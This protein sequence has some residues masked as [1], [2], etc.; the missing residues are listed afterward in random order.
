MGKDYRMK[1]GK[2]RKIQICNEYILILGLIMC[3]GKDLEQYQ[4]ILKRVT[5][6]S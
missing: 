1:E 6:E 5:F 3:I 2:I 4:I